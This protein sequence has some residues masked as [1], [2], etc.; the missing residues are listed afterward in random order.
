MTTIV[1]QDE[2]LQPEFAS[3]EERNHE[4]FL[5]MQKRRKAIEAVEN[6]QAEVDKINDEIL[7]RFGFD[8]HNC[9]YF[10]G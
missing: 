3:A 6:V 9:D 7:E 10:K 1:E 2:G 5:I 8:Y 4:F